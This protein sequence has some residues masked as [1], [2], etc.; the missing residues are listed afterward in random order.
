MTP[1]ANFISNV[2]MLLYL[3]GKQGNVFRIEVYFYRKGLH[4][5]TI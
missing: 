3:T 4:L 5:A 1:L 2:K